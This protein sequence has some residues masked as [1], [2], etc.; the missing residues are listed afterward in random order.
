M[1]KGTQYYSYPWECYVG[2]TM[3]QGIVHDISH[4]IEFDDLNDVM[5][6]LID[7]RLDIVISIIMDTSH[8][9]IIV[10]V[11]VIAWYVNPIDTKVWIGFQKMLFS[12]VWYITKEEYTIRTSLLFHEE[13]RRSV[14]VAPKIYSEVYLGLVLNDIT[15]CAL[16]YTRNWIR[17]ETTTYYGFE[18]K[19]FCF[20]IQLLH[21]SF[22]LIH[23][24]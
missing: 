10:L 20:P 18:L 8:W 11:K 16:S 3:F 12:I 21:T 4:Y 14:L 9:T 17:Y 23:P 15:T 22:S 5:N 19:L 13:G 24:R 1:A 6:Q 2:L 7:C